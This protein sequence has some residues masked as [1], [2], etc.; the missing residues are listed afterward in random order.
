MKKA[1]IMLIVT[2]KVDVQM[3]EPNYSL[4]LRPYIPGF[5]TDH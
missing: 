4:C 1:T 5:M 2:T 3:L